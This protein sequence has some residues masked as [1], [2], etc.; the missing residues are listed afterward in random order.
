[1][2][3]LRVV[4][5]AL[6]ILFS[7]R[8]QVGPAMA[9]SATATVSVRLGIASRV[10]V[11]ADR[12]VVTLEPGGTETVNITVKAR[13]AASDA[14]VVVLDTALP[15]ADAARVTYKFAGTTGS[16]GGSTRLGTIRGSG[17][18][19]LP[20]TLTLAPEA[21]GPVTLELTVHVALD[22]APVGRS[23]AAS[24]HP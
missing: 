19:T 9:A 24:V 15:A 14:A 16:L 7:S 12:L 22:G 10:A 11:E 8:L 2:A 18:H 13:M 3:A 17:V 6:A 23:G 20:L 5:T 1:M 21:P 4:L